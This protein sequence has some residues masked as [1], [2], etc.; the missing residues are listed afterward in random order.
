LTKAYKVAVINEFVATNKNI[1]KT[2]LTTF[3]LLFSI[4][5]FSQT[6]DPT[7]KK[8]VVLF[9]LKKDTSYF[10]TGTGII[11][12]YNKYIYIVTNQHI[13]KLTDLFIRFNVKSSKNRNVRYSI[14]K[15]VK[16]SKA[17]WLVAPNSDVAIVLLTDYPEVMNVSDTLDIMPMGISLFKNWDYLNE[18]DDIY[19]LGF[20]IG[21]GA[22]EHYSPV[23]RSGIISLKENKNEFL[24]DANIYPGN[25]GGPVF[26]KPSIFDYRHNSMG[27]TI[28]GYLIGIV[29]SYIPYNDI[30]IS[31]QTQRPRII[32]EENSGLAVV[33]STDVILNLLKQYD[34]K[35][36]NVH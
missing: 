6:L 17:P 3:F 23:Y 26:M 20:P 10:P 12:I 36:I 7:W 16:S 4:S 5:L 28:P 33:F 21:I 30:A 32:F 8:S 9:E 24:I 1:M 2:I 34:I 27:E 35:I 14:D 15:M 18:G 22:D 29:S 13:A 25:S 31:Q 19:I 11:I